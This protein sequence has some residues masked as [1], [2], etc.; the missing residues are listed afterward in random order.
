VSYGRRDLSAAFSEL[1]VGLN[2]AMNTLFVKGP[3]VENGK[4]GGGSAM[5]R[6]GIPGPF[7]R[8]WG[9]HHDSGVS[10]LANGVVNNELWLTSH[11]AL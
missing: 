2:D 6:E 7:G 5:N 1:Y 4:A 10:L 3:R 8:I 11:L 9:R